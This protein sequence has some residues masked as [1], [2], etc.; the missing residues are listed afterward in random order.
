LSWPAYLGAVPWVGLED[1]VAGDVVGVAA[2]GDADAA[3]LGRQGVRQ[4]V[5]VEV[6][7]GDDVE[8]GRPGQHLL[9]GDVGDGVLHQDLVPR[10][11]AAVLPGDGDVGELLL[12]ELVA[13][14]VE[15]ALGVLHDVAL[16][17]EVHVLAATVDRVLEGGA[18]EA[19]RARSWRSA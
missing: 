15:G 11:A 13:P 3:D 5:A 1:A 9:E 2:G 8:L 18:L 7:R 17:H 14:L 16:V 10:L 19:L 4:V 6:H 12:D